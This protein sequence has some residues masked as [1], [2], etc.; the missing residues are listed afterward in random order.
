MFAEVKD[1]LG[2]EEPEEQALKTAVKKGLYGPIYSEKVAFLLDVSGS[3]SAGTEEGTRLEIAVRELARVLGSQMTDDTYFN[4]IPFSEE[5]TPFAKKLQRAKTKTLE[6]TINKLPKLKP[7][8]ETNAFGALEAAFADPNVDTIY[9][10]SDGSPTVGEEFIPD[11]I[12]LRVD[13]W[14]RDRRVIIN[15]I[16]FF[17]GTAKNQDKAEARDFLRQLAQEN[18]GFYKEIY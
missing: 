1:M 4:I 15:C 3:M 8:G 2:G 12:R 13:E 9:L 10:L 11:L 17:P 18:E 5:A 6:K 16:G 14:N 7:G